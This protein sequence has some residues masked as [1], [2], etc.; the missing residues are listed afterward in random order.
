MRLY[1]NRRLQIHLHIL[2]SSIAH[3]LRPRL[4]IL[5]HLFIPFARLSQSLSLLRLFNLRVPRQIFRQ[6][7]QEIRQEL[8]SVALFIAIKV[9]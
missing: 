3:T 6:L 9:W 4:M 7:I 8:L 1:I 2:I 5:L